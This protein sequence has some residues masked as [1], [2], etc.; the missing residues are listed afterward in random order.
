M[1]VPSPPWAK[2]R[3]RSRWYN[4][5]TGFPFAHLPPLAIP[6]HGGRD[7]APGTRDSILDQLEDDVHEWDV[8]LADDED[9]ELLE[10]G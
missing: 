10:Q 4:G 2:C 7:L 5:R 1:S 9:S 8:K 3:K 6:H